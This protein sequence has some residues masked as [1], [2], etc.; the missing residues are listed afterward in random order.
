M[1]TPDHSWRGTRSPP[2][3]PQLFELS[4]LLQ[5]LEIFAEFIFIIQ[6]HGYLIQFSVTLDETPCLQMQLLSFAGEG[7]GVIAFFQEWLGRSIIPKVGMYGHRCKTLFTPNETFPD[8]TVMIYS[9]LSK[10]FQNIFYCIMLSI[11]GKVKNLARPMLNAG[12]VLFLVPSVAACKLSRISR[13]KYKKRVHL[14]QEFKIYDF[15]QLQGLRF[16]L[17]GAVEDSVCREVCGEWS[18]NKF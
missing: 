4:A 5:L 10:D 12:D 15:S 6:F 9:E 3:F 8:L 14:Q 2:M 16:C 11:R 7:W 18:S 1:Q 13:K 17:S